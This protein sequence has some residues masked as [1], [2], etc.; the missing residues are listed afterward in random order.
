M[1]TAEKEKMDF[2]LSGHTHGGQITFFG[3]I[4]YAPIKWKE[5]YGYGEKEYAGNKMYITSGLGGTAF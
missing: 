1:K 3:K 2:M 5:K 4:L